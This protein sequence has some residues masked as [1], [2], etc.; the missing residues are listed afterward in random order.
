MR[1][2]GI[3]PGTATVGYGVVEAAPDGRCELLAYGVIRTSA[4]EPMGDRLLTIHQDVSTLIAQFQP[5]LAVVE[6]LFA[7]RNVTN[8]IT[9]SQAR[10]VILLALV[11][12]EVPFAEYTPMQVKQ[13]VA[14][15]GRAEKLAVQE[16]VRDLLALPILPKP[17][18]AADALAFALCHVQHLP[19]LGVSV[20]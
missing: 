12:H 4:S 1:I 20:G 3:D 2:L 17:D 13:T 19:A 11:Q 8:V 14:G 10:G 5:T 18:D 15:H 9:V 7:F 16:A 6:K